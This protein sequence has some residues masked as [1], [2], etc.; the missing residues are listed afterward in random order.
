M[1]LQWYY[2][3]NEERIVMQYVK[4]PFRELCILTGGFELVVA[5]YHSVAE[6]WASR[7]PRLLRNLCSSSLQIA[8]WAYTI[9]WK[10][11]IAS[12]SANPLQ[13]NHFPCIRQQLYRTKAYHYVWPKYIFRLQRSISSRLLLYVFPASAQLLY[14]ETAFKH[15]CMPKPRLFTVCHSALVLDNAMV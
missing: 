1:K 10:S 15:N 12:S 14:Q 8:Y 5:F 3:Q 7:T 9:L 13:S 2:R 4:R 11:P 6:N